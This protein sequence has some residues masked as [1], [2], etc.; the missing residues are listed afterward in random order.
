MT[1]QKQKEISEKCS[2]GKTEDYIS[3]YLLAHFGI[4]LK[5]LEEMLSKHRKKE[6]L[7]E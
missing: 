7:N 1:D 4:K 3:G 6:T 2:L 5:E